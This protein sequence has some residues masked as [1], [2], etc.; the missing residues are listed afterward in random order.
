MLNFAALSSLSTRLGVQ[1]CGTVS[2]AR[3]FT[4]TGGDAG[5][6]KFDVTSTPE[7]IQATFPPYSITV[8]DLTTSRPPR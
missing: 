1:G 5:F 2:A 3:A 4:Y 7:G 6:Q 8:L